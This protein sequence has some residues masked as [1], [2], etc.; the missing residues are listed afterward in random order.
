MKCPSPPTFFRS[1]RQDFFDSQSL[2]LKN[3]YQSQTRLMFQK[4]IWQKW[5]DVEVVSFSASNRDQVLTRSN[6]QRK[7]APQCVEV[8][9]DCQSMNSQN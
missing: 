4:T 9:W 1:L 7:Q 3:R 6:F 2:L 8:V 5:T